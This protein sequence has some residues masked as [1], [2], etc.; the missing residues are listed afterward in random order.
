[1]KEEEKIT[2]ELE[3][4][5]TKEFTEQGTTTTLDLAL[6]TKYFMGKNPEIQEELKHIY[7]A[8]ETSNFKLGEY[9]YFAKGYLKKNRNLPGTFE[10]DVQ[11]GDLSNW[12]IIGMGYAYK[13]DYAIKCG[14]RVLLFS[15][16]G[17]NLV[18]HHISKVKV[19]E[20][21][22]EKRFYLN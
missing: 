16:L 22:T 17:D 8:G 5:V 19:G 6:A 7:G 14:L 10:Q 13:I 3:N 12:Q 21:E 4:Q 15:H 18:L 9:L 1:M 11:R 20:L 2:N